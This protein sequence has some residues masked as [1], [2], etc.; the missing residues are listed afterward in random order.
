M[1]LT[2]QREKTAYAV[3]FLL[4]FAKYK[5]ALSFSFILIVPDEY[6]PIGDYD[7][8][9]FAEE[10]SDWLSDEH[11]FCHK[12]F[13]LVFMTSDDLKE[14]EEKL[15][16]AIYDAGVNAIEEFLGHPLENDSTDIESEM[17]DALTNIPDE[18]YLQYLAKYCYK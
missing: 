6:I 2:F 10:I 17:D 5:S 13:E 4:C 11:E 16:R 14:E 18:E 9:E 1:F 8:D 3:F 15:K 7:A 12:G